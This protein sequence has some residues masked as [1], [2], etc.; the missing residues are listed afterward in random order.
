MLPDE[1]RCPYCKYEFILNTDDGKYRE[2][3]I[4]PCECPNCLNE[5]LV[6]TWVIYSHRE[7]PDPDQGNIMEV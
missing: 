6:E 1:V 2:E 4:E 3:G 7:I 5:F